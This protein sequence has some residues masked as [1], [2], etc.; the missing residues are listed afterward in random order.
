MTNPHS[1]DPR[2]AADPGRPGGARLCVNGAELQA[3]VSGALFWPTQETLVVSDLHL[4]K[5]SFFASRGQLLPP[6][7]TAA[8]LR[9]LEALVARL[10]PARVV[11]LGDS[12]HDPAAAE[13]LD[14][15]AAARIEALTRDRDWV[16][17]CGNHDPAPPADWGGRVAQDLTLG[18]LV[19]RHEALPEGPTAGEVSGHFHPKASVRVRAR[20]LTARCF[21]TDGRRLILPAFGALTGGLDVGSPAITRLFAEGFVA[22]LLGRDRIFAFPGTALTSPAEP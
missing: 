21:V 18:P 14:G 6:Y 5:A 10:R 15:A 17:I 12:F 9:G 11:S 20:R 22:H 4:E 2:P 16:W 13:R 8:T 3:D 7:D 1:D 19:F